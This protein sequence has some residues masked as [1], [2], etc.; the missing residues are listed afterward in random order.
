M[1]EEK[2][3]SVGELEELINKEMGELNVITNILDQKKS[4]FNDLHEEIYYSSS[5]KIKPVKHLP[6]RTEGKHA[7]NGADDKENLPCKSREKVGF[8]SGQSRK[9]NVGQQ[10]P[11]LK[12]KD[13]Q[14]H[15]RSKLGS[16]EPVQGNFCENILAKNNAYAQF[17]ENLKKMESQEKFEKPNFS[18]QALQNKSNQP[19]PSEVNETYKRGESTTNSRAR[20][21]SIR[22]KDSVSLSKLS[23]NTL[24]N[25]GKYS[26]LQ[27]L[28]DPNSNE[29]F[30]HLDLSDKKD[31]KSND[32]V[33]VKKFEKSNPAFDED[34]LFS[35]LNKISQIDD[36]KEEVE[37]T[38][39]DDEMTNLRNLINFEKGSYIKDSTTDGEN[40]TNGD[41]KSKSKNTNN[42]TSMAT[43]QSKKSLLKNSN[44][45]SRNKILNNT[46]SHR[47]SSK[48]LIK[49]ISK[50]SSTRN[51]SID[52]KKNTSHYEKLSY[53]YEPI[54]IED[55]HK[56]GM[57][58][59]NNPL[60]I[61]SD[62]NQQNKPLNKTRDNSR[63]PSRKPQMQNDQEKKNTK[64]GNLA[65]AF[66]SNGDSNDY[67][68]DLANEIEL[69]KVKKVKKTS[70]VEKENS[71]TEQY[72]TNIENV[73][74]ESDHIYKTEDAE[75]FIR[76]KISGFNNKKNFI[77]K[78]KKNITPRKQNLHENCLTSE[79]ES[80]PTKPVAY[81]SPLKWEPRVYKRKVEIEEHPYQ[82]MLSKNSLLIAQNLKDPRERQYEGTKAS[83]K[84]T[85]NMQYEIEFEDSECT[86]KP[87]INEMS[88]HIDKRL[89]K[90]EEGKTRF[91]MLNEMS[92]YYEARRDLLVQRKKEEEDMEI[93]TLSFRPKKSTKPVYQPHIQIGSDVATR[94]SQWQA[95]KQEKINMEKKKKEQIETSHSYKPQ[96]NSTY[97][98][99][100]PD[101]QDYFSSR[102]MQQGLMD[103]FQR[104]EK[105]KKEKE[106]KDIR[107]N[108]K[109]ITNDGNTQG[110]ATGRTGRNYQTPS[111]AYS[112]NKPA[113]SS[114]DKFE[115]ETVKKLRSDQLRIN[116]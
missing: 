19:S 115:K 112:S 51:L 39:N 61:L 94:T 107:L 10:P 57:A 47:N 85:K 113:F 27:S 59:K 106:E 77:E 25:T 15:S 20:K 62:V 31:S 60:Q 55:S 53:N 88:K 67:F 7:S 21:N 87:K 11:K 58:K 105:A 52:N 14:S 84:K 64:S 73:E 46:G 80:L 103:H 12:P 83:D 35:R 17:S 81:K 6:N 70:K 5:K 114:V 41:K 3:M 100:K 82:P 18:N 8:G 95:K 28:K 23:H 34:D 101:S 43:Q 96:L 109:K 75:E 1:A 30:Y 99:E 68:Y 56:L 50:R 72:Q 102:F 49:P 13:Q 76:K 22:L 98:A 9:L 32:K 104:I 97:V 37:M 45:Q 54:T 36:L 4:K 66:E 65:Q 44:S 93:N 90:E 63:K 2:P 89:V 48:E 71:L 42:C 24:T 91:E 69:S 74:T 40:H 116:M 38:Y 33:F 78:N 110:N 111:K 108:G 26:C 79:Y 29:K 92:D 86:F 16:V